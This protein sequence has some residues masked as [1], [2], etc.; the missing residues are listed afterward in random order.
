MSISMMSLALAVR[1]AISRKPGM[2]DVPTK[3]II[4]LAITRVSKAGI[5]I[6]LDNLVLDEPSSRCWAP[7]R[8]QAKPARSQVSARVR[9]PAQ[10]FV[11][12]SPL[13]GDG[14]ELSV[15][16]CGRAIQDDGY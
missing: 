7:P 6:N 5:S 3:R 14:F 1:R 13:E 9:L 2:T 15:P 11:P 12:D 4:G 16:V 10:R 8:Y